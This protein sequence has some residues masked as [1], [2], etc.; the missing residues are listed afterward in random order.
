MKVRA[1]E[2]GFHVTIR[3]PNDEFDIE[4]PIPGWCTPVGEAAPLP[5]QVADDTGD[6]VGGDG[7]GAPATGFVSYH[8][9]GGRYGIKDASGERFGEFVGT[10]EEAA[11]EAERLNTPDP[12]LTDQDDGLPDA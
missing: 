7:A 3:E 12:D 2:K 5:P 10:K 1:L 11:A 6:G 9:G 8:V 4:P